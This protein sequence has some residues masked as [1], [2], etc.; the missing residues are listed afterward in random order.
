M[1][2]NENPTVWSS[3]QGDVRKKPAKP[4]PPQASLPPA[5][6]IVYLHRDSKGRAGK[7]VTLL[8]GLALTGTDL[9]ALAKTLK[10]SLGVGGTVKDGLIELQ[11]HDREKIAALLRGLGYQVKLAGG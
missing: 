6:Q 1:P 4:A 7:G 11:S 2:K 8:K 5:R 9:G 3:A 10:G